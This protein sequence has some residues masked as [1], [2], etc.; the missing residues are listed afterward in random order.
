MTYQNSPNMHQPARQSGA[1]L[2]IG[3]VLLM[4]LTIIG[5]GVLST[6]SL[7]QRMAGNMADLNM[8]FN[9]AETVGR[10][11]STQAGTI[12]GP[13]ERVCNLINVTPCVTEG[14]DDNWWDTSNQNWWA[15]NAITATSFIDPINGVSTQ[16]QIVIE[17]ER[18]ITHSQ[19]RGV[20]YQTP[21]VDFVR[22]TTRG[23][24]ASNNTEVIIQQTI[25]KQ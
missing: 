1:A 9:A 15:N 18:H 19:V 13:M 2:I 17:I 21:G 23:T 20:N 3:L 25:V 16:P 10:A 11:L 24:G 8:A 6:T 4:S 22:L 14:L 12:L 7:E 5:V